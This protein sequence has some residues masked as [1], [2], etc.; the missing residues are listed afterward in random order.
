MNSNSLYNLS[1][2]TAVAATLRS[3]FIPLCSATSTSPRPTFESELRPAAQ[4][5]ISYRR[6]WKKLFVK[7]IFIGSLGPDRK[8]VS[9]DLRRACLEQEGR[10]HRRSRS[11][12]NFQLHRLLRDLFGHI[13]AAVKSD[14]ERN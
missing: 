12:R 4:S 1:C 11:C 9:R 13:G 14:R 7:K 2:S 10:R 5:V 6:P 8:T 3:R